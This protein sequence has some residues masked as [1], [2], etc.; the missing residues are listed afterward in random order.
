MQL[1]AIPNDFEDAVA[2]ALAARDRTDEFVSSVLSRGLDK[3]VLVGCG[4]SHFRM[5]PRSTS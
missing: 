4:G 1:I 3:V 2:Y 5:Y